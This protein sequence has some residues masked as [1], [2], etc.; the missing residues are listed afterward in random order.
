M[1]TPECELD[2]SGGMEKPEQTSSDVLVIAAFYGV[3]AVGMCYMLYR[4]LA[5]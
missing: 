2:Y 1:F 3:P 5:S 4:L